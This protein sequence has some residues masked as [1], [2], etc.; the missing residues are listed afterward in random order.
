[1]SIGADI[2]IAGRPPHP[3]NE[4]GGDGD[5]ATCAAP[6]PDTPGSTANS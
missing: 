5:W 2:V 4:D 3:G 6:M 1:M